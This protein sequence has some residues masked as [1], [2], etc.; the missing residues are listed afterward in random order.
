MQQADM[1]NKFIN[2]KCIFGDVVEKIK[3]GTSPGIQA[4]DIQK[5][6]GILRNNASGIL[7]NL[8][9]KGTLVK[10][11]SRPVTFL[12]Y[13]IISR[14]YE[15]YNIPFKNIYTLQELQEKV[16][17]ERLN[18]QDPFAC[19]LGY[20]SSLLYQVRQAKAAIV[21]PPKGLHT[22]LLGDS[23]VGKTTFA[24]AIHAYGMLVN[25]KNANNYPF[26]TFN[27]A[28]YFNNP[29]LLLSQLFGHSKNAFTGADHDKSGLVE[30]ADGGVLFLDEIHR[31]PPDGQE[32]LF[33]LMDKGEYNRLGDSRKRKSSI[34]IIA[35]TTENP[36]TALLNTFMRRIP[37]NIILPNYRDK[38]IAEKIEIIEYFF[39]YEAINLKHPVK[40]APE[41]L[42][43][44]ALYE[45][46]V[47]N[48]GQLRSEIRL[49]CA[50]AFLEYLQNNQTIYIN[51]QML[52]K[53]IRTVL[54]NYA[55]M[56]KAV[57]CYLDMFSEDIEI[58]PEEDSKITFAEVENNIYDVIV[59]KL[60]KLKEQGTTI[61]NI[62]DMLKNEIDTYLGGVNKYF[63]NSRSNITNLY[64]LVSKEV[65][66]TTIQFIEYA[67]RKLNVNF[68]NYFLFGL[69]L[70]IQAL[71][72]RSGQKLADDDNRHLFKI[73]AKHPDEF[74]AA[75]EMVKLLTDKF[76]IIMPESEKGFLALLLCHSKIE[77][78][79]SKIGV[80]VVCHGESTAMSM[81]DTCN[82]LLN[83]DLMKAIDMPLYQSV[84]ETYRKLKAMVL[85]VNKG[86][87]VILLVDMGSLL[88]FDKRLTADTGIKVKLIGAVSTP[89][90]LGVLRHVL[91]D[92]GDIDDIYIKES[93]KEQQ[94]NEPVKRKSL[95]VLAV[96]TTGKGSSVI[97]K[98]MLDKLLDKYYVNSIKVFTVDYVNVRKN[99]ELLSKKYN[100]VAAVGNIDPMLPIPFF[101]INQLVSEQVQQVFFHLLDGSMEGPVSLPKT[102]QIPTIYETAKELLEKYVKFVNPR[103][104]IFK[105][106]DFIDVIN[107]SPHNKNLT[108]DLI[109][110]IGCALD[111]CVGKINI[112]FD[113]L[114][115]FYVINKELFVNIHKALRPI[116]ED[117][118]IKV[119]DAEIAYI[120]KIIT[121]HA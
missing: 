117:Y 59:G 76:G 110:H 55:K 69:S 114:D 36:A 40:I 8:C 33:Y 62:N 94:E 78:D 23:G 96:C 113:D 2:E 29:Q 6:L 64:K 84:D 105:I 98:N 65:V 68:N 47:G 58:S 67:R 86:K 112:T 79:T 70:H 102:T 34:L 99:Y 101:P 20:D 77:A 7:N 19:L 51:Y 81:A 3:N 66:D 103:H 83:T 85:T 71:L 45:F 16:I 73:K 14:L 120:V 91:Y 111:R 93:Q 108:L 10:I 49:L 26:V 48:I 57:T 80:I 31:L 121:T 24:Q 90:A 32:M 17:D 18:S 109:I 27:C 1:V 106:R 41:V 74:E 60:N 107:Y 88:T 87:G 37:V 11:N 12:P 13:K 9:K 25:N 43:A 56:D 92:V 104:A 100:M 72:K 4:I 42:K 50:T 5:Q 53:D 28:D 118:N 116:E 15:Q 63:S 21:Y 52:N 75:G 35:A 119:S 95:A 61:E 46:S 54:F 30:K 39:K 22:L 82:A 115:K 38:P 44:L 97:V 89:L